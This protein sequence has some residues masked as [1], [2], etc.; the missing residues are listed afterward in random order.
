ME[1]YSLQFQ[2]C[3]SISSPLWGEN[4]YWSQL[5]S[6]VAPVS[7]GKT[8]DGAHWFNSWP[9]KKN[10]FQGGL[11]CFQYKLSFLAHCSH[12]LF[13]CVEL[14]FGLLS[15]V[16]KLMHLQDCGFGEM[17]VT[18]SSMSALVRPFPS[19][20][21]H[22]HLQVVSTRKLLA[23]SSHAEGLSSVCSDHVDFETLP[24]LENFC[25]TSA[26]VS[27]FFR[28]KAF[29]QRELSCASSSCFH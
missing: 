15:A 5:V 1:R 20:S 22:V 19:V 27:T 28:N 25:T 16:E 9:N 21:V 17:F 29:P 3:A 4:I 11:S 12:G 26:F 8:R 6:I 23:H 10:D 7:I 24:T 2:T 14:H 18:I 13:S